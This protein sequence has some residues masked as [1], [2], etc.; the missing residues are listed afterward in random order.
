MGSYAYITVSE[1]TV[2]KSPRVLS[3][4]SLSIDTQKH[5]HTTLLHILSEPAYILLR[6]PKLIPNPDEYEM[7]K[8]DTRR[9]II[10]GAM[11]TQVIC[12]KTK[13][14]LIKELKYA[15]LTLYEEGY[16]AWDFE[17]YKQ[18]DGTIMI[19]DFDKF[20]EAGSLTEEF[21]KHPCFPRGFST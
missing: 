6:A 3:S 19:L 1:T 11:G 20:R 10:L 4:T 14:R 17:L 2:I 18:P 13:E 8:I 5:I 16:A 21:F 15:W 9:P 12:P 7:E